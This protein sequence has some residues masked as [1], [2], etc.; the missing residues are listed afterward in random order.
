M[1]AT[2]DQREQ[3]D[4]PIVSGESI[5]SGESKTFFDTRTLFS[6]TTNVAT[7]T[8]EILGPNGAVCDPDMAMVTVDV[9]LPPQGPYDCTKPIKR[10]GMIW[11]GTQ[12]VTVT[13][14]K[15]H[16]LGTLLV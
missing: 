7:V 12:D 10:I 11:D 2:L 9:T 16:R 14:W 13:A 15:A 4:D 6:T 8:G 3:V 1:L 5:P